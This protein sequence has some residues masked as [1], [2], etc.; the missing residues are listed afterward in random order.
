MNEKNTPLSFSY[1]VV[2]IFI[3]IIFPSSGYALNPDHG[4][5]STCHKLHAA[6]GQVLTNQSTVEVLCLTCHGPAGV[7]VNKADIHKNLDDTIVAGCADC[8]NAHNNIGNS[9]GGVNIK[10]VG[11]RDGTALIRTPNSGDRNVIF[12]S[13]GTD[14]AGEPSLHSFADGDEDGNGSY[15]GVCE[16]CHSLTSTKYHRNNSTGGHMH[17]V[18]ETC[19]RCHTHV[20]FFKPAGGGTCSGC[21]STIWD[22]FSAPNNGHHVMGGTVTEEDCGVCHSEPG[23]NHMD[24][25]LDLRDP[26]TGAILT[27][28]KGITRNTSSDTLEADVL[29]LQN[30]FC[31]KCHDVDGAPATF[32][33]TGGGT[34]VSPFSSSNTVPDTNSQ[35]NTSNSYHHAVQGAGSNTYCNSTTM[36]PPWNQGDHDVITC[37]DCHELS[38]HGS[39]N[40]RMLRTAIDLD[41]MESG[42]LSTALG[43]SVETFCTLCHKYDEYG[44][45]GTAGGNSKFEFH[46]TNQNQHGSGGGND[47]GCMGCHGGVYDEGGISGNGSARGNIHGGNY[48]W[49]SSSWAN[50][51]SSQFFM[52]GGFISGWKLN[53]SAGKSGC[54]GG[55][56][57]HP[58]RV[59]KLEPGKEYTN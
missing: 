53:S 27:F 37:F 36:E 50:G 28:P 54:G 33:S 13:R 9:L 39:A 12:E 7:A 42:V 11:H 38:G 29:N 21:H 22:K 2:F 6:P 44:T 3:L 14:D 57:A 16:V 48:S 24:G 26:D 51:S 10:Q 23:S 47:L 52:V 31:M 56:C 58:G 18:G 19:T 32:N 17:Y 34:D 55:T 15:D 5:C 35:F 59:S 45:T 43:D 46:G 20:G 49:G 1:L 4:T 30:N 40:Q 41:S 25:D 8:H